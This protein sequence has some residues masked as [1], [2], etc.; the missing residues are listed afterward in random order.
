MSVQKNVLF[1]EGKFFISKSFEKKSQKVL[2]SKLFEK[3]SQNF[4]AE[5]SWE[6]VSTMLILGWATP[7]FP[8]RQSLIILSIIIVILIL[9]R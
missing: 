1:T 6:K 4:C 5:N 8:N 3:Q 7:T 2:N 9:F